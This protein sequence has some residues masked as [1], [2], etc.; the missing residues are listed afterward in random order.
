[1]Y[2]I[3]IWVTTGYETSKLTE[4][5]GGILCLFRRTW[6]GRGEAWYMVATKCTHI[7]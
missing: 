5:L 2:Y 1:M 7:P 4:V 6:V 3:H